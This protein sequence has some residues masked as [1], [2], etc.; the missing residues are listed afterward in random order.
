[1]IALLAV[2]ELSVLFFDLVLLCLAEVKLADFSNEALNLSCLAFE[3]DGA[4]LVFGI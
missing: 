2:G 3:H 1:M 4:G